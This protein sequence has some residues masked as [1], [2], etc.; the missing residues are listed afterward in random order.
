M[1][2]SPEFLKSE[3]YLNVSTNKKN[4]VNKALI[5]AAHAIGWNLK[6]S[7]GLYSVEPLQNEG[8]L[9]FI[10]CYDRS[11]KNVPKYS[12]AYEKRPIL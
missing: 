2:L 10:S 3:I 9:V 1:D 4:E 12:Y 8:N 7:N 11:V 6:Q 5:R